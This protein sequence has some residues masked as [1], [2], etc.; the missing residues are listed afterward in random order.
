MFHMTSHAAVRAQQRGY[1]PADIDLIVSHGSDVQGGI[2]LM[3]HDVERVAPSLG[4]SRR[5]APA[6]DRLARLAGSFIPITNGHV[7]SIYRPGR[8]RCRR[9]QSR[10]GR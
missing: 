7:L 3:K 5:N 2:L 10:L 6:L 1:R 4:G 9:L 8:R